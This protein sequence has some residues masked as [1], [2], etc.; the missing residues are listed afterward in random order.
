MF[1]YGVHHPGGGNTPSDFDFIKTGGSG[2]SRGGRARARAKIEER[3]GDQKGGIGG[4]RGKIKT[5]CP[6]SKG[7]FHFK[8]KPGQTHKN[9]TARYGRYGNGKTK[10]G[11]LV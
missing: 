5:S 6:D 9:S 3:D 8:I 4:Q 7:I 10:T 1:W 2:V 11:L